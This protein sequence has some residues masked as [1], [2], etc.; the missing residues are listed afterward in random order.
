MAPSDEDMVRHCVSK[1]N[2]AA[3]EAQRSFAKW[4]RLRR[5]MT[6][7]YHVDVSTMC[8]P[9][10]GDL[11]VLKE[12][13]ERAEARATWWVEKEKEYDAQR[14]LWALQAITHSHSKTN[15]LITFQTERQRSMGS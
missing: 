4:N 8:Q 10:A 9:C 13:M 2:A 11:K 3:D 6:A 7:K 1:A 14:K 5:Q 12:K 15:L